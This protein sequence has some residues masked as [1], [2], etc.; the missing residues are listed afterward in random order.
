[1]W[2]FI[3]LSEDGKYGI[4][5]NQTSIKKL[6]QNE[7]CAEVKLYPS[8]VERDK[9]KRNWKLK[10]QVQQEFGTKVNQTEK[11]AAL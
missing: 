5:V 8:Q 9:I 10:R 2:Q 11:K 3:P 6:N 7:V 4:Y 1:M